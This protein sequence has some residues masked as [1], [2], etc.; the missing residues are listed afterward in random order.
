[1]DGKKW[2]FAVCLTII[3]LVL[4]LAVLSGVS[5]IQVRSAFHINLN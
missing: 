2:L 1:M 3:V 5:D 4:A